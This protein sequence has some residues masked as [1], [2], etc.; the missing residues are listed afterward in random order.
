[1]LRYP[2]SSPWS[3]FDSGRLL[4]PVSLT[5]A[6]LPEGLRC[7]SFVRGRVRWLAGRGLTE[8]VSGGGG[9]GPGDFVHGQAHVV[10]GE[11]RRCGPRARHVVELGKL[12]T[13]L[14]LVFVAEAV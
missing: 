8:R 10:L 6:P 7:R 14:K 1:M 3:I 2:S 11:A 13:V 9:E 5:L 4:L 12:H